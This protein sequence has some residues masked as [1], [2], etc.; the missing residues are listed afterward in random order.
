MRLLRKRGG[1]L[2]S[3]PPEVI[4][5]LDAGID[6]LANARTFHKA[7]IHLVEGRKNGKRRENMS[8]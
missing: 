5:H 7:G 2:A 4:S 8:V 1:E 3:M 6:I